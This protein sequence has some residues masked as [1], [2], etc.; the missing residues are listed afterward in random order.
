[1]S[2]I[3]KFVGF[4]DLEESG[5]QWQTLKKLGKSAFKMSKKIFSYNNNNSTY[6]VTGDGQLKQNKQYL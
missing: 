2:F 5:Q 3:I 4:N 1:M 6:I